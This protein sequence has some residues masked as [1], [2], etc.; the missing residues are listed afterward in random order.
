M[1]VFN[2]Y[3]YGTIIKQNCKYFLKNVL[4]SDVKKLTS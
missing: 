2:L 4:T 1:F 3:K